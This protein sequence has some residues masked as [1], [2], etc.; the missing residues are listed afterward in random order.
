MRAELT[1]RARR[2]A[3]IAVVALLVGVLPVAPPPVAGANPP[4]PATP[5]GTQ[6]LAVDAGSDYTCAIRPDGTLACWGG[7]HYG[8]ATPPAGT[9]KV[10]SAGG[11]HTCA[12]KDDDTLACWGLDD[13]GEATPPAGTFKVV[14]AGWGSTCA[15]RTDGRLLCWGGLSTSMAGTFAAVG[16]GWGHI[17]AIKDD[18]TL[19]CWGSDGSG[20]ATPPAGTFKA[21]SVGGDHTCAIRDDDTLACWGLDDYGEATP[22]AGTFKVVS[23]GSEHTCA[24]GNDDRLTCWGW[25]G[26]DQSSPP[27]GTFS[28][29]S[30]GGSHTCAMGTDGTLA[31][32]GNNDSGQATPSPTAKITSLPARLATT[33]IPL[34]WSARHAFAAVT[35]YDVRYRRAKWNAGFGAQATWLSEAPGTSATFPASPGYTY[36]FSVRA[37][38]A[39]GGVS[40]WTAET[41]TAIPLDDRSLTR[42]GKWTAGTSSSYYRSTWLRSYTAGATLTRT[43][44]KAASISLLVTTCRTC[45]TVKVYWNSTRLKTISL[46]SATTVTKRLIAVKSFGYNRS[47][48]LTIKVSSSGKK[49]IIDGVAIHRDP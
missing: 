26:S 33:A 34:A 13:Y 22:P 9:F 1:A 3:G 47:G 23:A 27:D 11:Y 46:Y 25:N 2:W 19:A 4:A 30:A 49:V 36:C 5:T 39:D 45:G 44:V 43:G 21:M 16:T 48:T 38:D 32:W 10:V 28:A 12:I 41:C 35:S 29:V 17:C 37:R 40:P 42:S 24:I 18:R 14:S 15:I 31:C 6:V 7:D 8:Q 20:E